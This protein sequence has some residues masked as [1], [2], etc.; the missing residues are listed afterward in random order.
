MDL[1]ESSSLPLS[2]HIGTA[3]ICPLESP[4]K[5]VTYGSVVLAVISEDGREMGEASGKKRKD[6]KL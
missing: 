6:A 3:K 4:L 5:G 1:Y 2:N